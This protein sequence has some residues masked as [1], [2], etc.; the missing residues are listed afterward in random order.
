MFFQE[1]M[2]NPL[3]QGGYLLKNLNES[4]LF[5]QNINSWQRDKRIISRLLTSLQ[6]LNDQIIWCAPVHQLIIDE[7]QNHPS[8][9]Q[10]IWIHPSNFFKTKIDTKILGNQNI[11]ILD[12]EK[13]L[14]WFV[15]AINQQ[16]KFKI[17]IHPHIQRKNQLFNDIQKNIQK[18]LEHASR[19]LKTITHF[20]NI[21]KNNY[22]QNQKFY[23]KVR[24]ISKNSKLQQPKTIILGGSSVDKILDSHKLKRPIWCAD[25]AIYPLIKNNIIPEIIISIDASRHTLEHFMRL[26]IK[27][28]AHT[29]LIVDPLGCPYLFN[30]PFAK[31][32]TY[33]SN[34]PL[35]RA[36]KHLKKAVQLQNIEGTTFGFIESL[37]E[38]LF[39]KNLEKESTIKIYGND[40]YKNLNYV[41]HLRGSSYYWKTFMKTSRTLAIENFFFDLSLRLQK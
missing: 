29:T 16:T 18:I 33:K 39:L 28:I 10:L 35:I 6:N 34:N 37:Y 38:Y 40:Q 2:C 36:E 22:L 15:N 20:S 11:I 31:I 27:E 1:V 12:N 32:Y 8:A 21:W 9:K 26:K 7:L 4:A 14:L 3:Q 19:R 24:L 25:T 23:H 17:H 30:L 41:T 5:Y 13:T